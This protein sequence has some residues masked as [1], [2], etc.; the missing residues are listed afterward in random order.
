MPLELERTIS[1]LEDKP[2]PPN[3]EDAD[4]I[5]V[6]TIENSRELK[7]SH[8]LT[9]EHNHKLFQILKD[10]QDVFAWSY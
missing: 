2:K 3:L 8:Q 4:T 10:Y 7:I 1:E 6:G 9:Q 5:N